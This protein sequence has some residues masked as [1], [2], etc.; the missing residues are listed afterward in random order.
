MKLLNDFV[1][2]TRS[3]IFG[4]PF[5]C[6]FYVTTDCDLRCKQCSFPQ[7]FR[8]IDINNKGNMTLEEIGVLAERLKRI[9][10]HNVLLSGGEPFSRK[11][12]PDIVRI[13]IRNKLSV[14]IVTNGAGLITEKRLQEVIDAG[15]DALQ[16]SFDSLR[17]DIH[18]EIA[19][20]Q[21]TWEK[22]KRT[23]EYA[24]RNLKNGMV[25]AITVVSSYNIHELPDIAQY[26]TSIGAYSIFQPVHLASDE[27][28]VGMLGMNDYREMHILQQDKTEVERVYNEL[29][30]MK[31]GGCNILSSNRFLKDSAAY[32]RT[33]KRRWSCDAYR[34]YVTIC[35]HGEVLPCLRFEDCAWLERMNI[36][37]KDFVEKYRSSPMQKKAHAYR[38]RCP[39]CVLSCYRE[40]SYLL[41][42]PSVFFDVSWLVGRRLLSR[43]IAP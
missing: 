17:P 41:R 19:Q 12:L 26:I 15:I 34:Y 14:R 38:E 1:H 2:F 8:K 35:P 5:F 16:V 25:C 6:H 30:R 31:K 33:R 11:D 9:G 4:T 42:Y 27:D 13:L 36:L 10:V 20:V 3:K 24:S 7:D 28:A 32:L 23:L 40:M 43:N 37:D 22:A 39:G 21:G 29:L 18:D